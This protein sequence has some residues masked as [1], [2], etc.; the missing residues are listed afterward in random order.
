MCVIGQR[1]LVCDACATVDETHHEAVE[2]PLHAEEAILADDVEALARL[3]QRLRTVEQH[4]D[5]RM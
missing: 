3:Q 1:R 2:Q 4:P 5:L